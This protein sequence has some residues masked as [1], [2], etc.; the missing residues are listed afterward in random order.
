MAPSQ[1]SQLKSALQGAGLSRQSQGKKGKK[2]SKAGLTNKDREKKQQKLDEIRSNLNKFDVR[3]QKTKNPVVGHGVKKVA[4]GVVGTPSL[5]RQRGLEMRRETLLPEQS[6]RRAGHTGQF[7]DRRFGEDNPHITPEERALERFTRAREIERSAGGKPGR[8][9]IFNLNDDEDGIGGGLGFGDDDLGGG[10][11]GAVK[12]T[13]GGREINDLRGDDFSMQGLMDDDEIE[14]DF[15]INATSGQDGEDAYARRAAMGAYGED[16]NDDPDRVKTKAE[17]MAE[18]IAKSKMYKHERQKQKELDDDMRMELDEGLEELRGLLDPTSALPSSSV[19]SKTAPAEEPEDEVTKE[20][21]QALKSAEHEP[22]YDQYVRSLAFDRRAQPKDRTKT[23]EE[24]IKEE[25]EKLEAA[26]KARLRRMRGEESEEEDEASRDGPISRRKRRAKGKD[27][28]SDD[29]RLPKRQAGGDDLDDDFYDDGVDA[30]EAYGLGQG[31]RGAGSDANSEMDD[32]DEDEEVSEEE[33]S[34]SGED[35]DDENLDDLESND[36]DDIDDDDDEQSLVK[37]P[38]KWKMATNGTGKKEIP[39][40]FPCPTTH[41]DLL[42]IMNGLEDKDIEVVVKRIRTLYH[43]SRGE[44]NKERLQDLLGILIDHILYLTSDPSSMIIVSGLLPHLTALVQLNPLTAAEHFKAKLDIMQKNLAKGLAKGAT[45]P[46]S[47]TFPGSAELTF[48]RIVGLVW[49]TSDFSHPIGAPAELLMGQYLSQ[50][51]VRSLKDMASGLFLCSIFL[52]F[53]AYSKR[54]IP[55]VLNF[56][57]TTFMILGPSSMKV[58]PVPGSFPLGDMLESTGKERLSGLKLRSKLAAGAA[59]RKPNFP[60]LLKLETEEVQADEE[61]VEQ[62]KVDLLTVVIRLVM[63][64]A[65]MYSEVEAFVEVFQ[66]LLELMKALQTSKIPKELKIDALTR[67]IKFAMQA[68]QPLSMQTFKPIPIPSYT[69]KFDLHFSAASR[70]HQDPDAERNEANKVKALYKK[71]RKG[72][73]RE[74]RK[75]NKFL[76]VERAKEQKAKDEAYEKK[77]RQVHGS[78]ATT[79]RAEEKA[80]E[81][82]KARDKRRSGRK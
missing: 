40:T 38:R 8:K 12:L 63:T 2:N 50:A 16:E 49:S 28:D 71:E 34:G 22:D 61:Q 48:L 69:P 55:E 72:A 58:S 23:E 19:F 79:E 7:I 17:V 67:I 24:T 64:S 52:Q 42:D 60:D 39:F 6:L 75:D 20:D 65:E 3:E 77:M 46:Q 81:R 56:F 36:D 25:A 54:I 82:D 18:V 32:E 45:L 78:I 37:P 27:K 44:G 41:D 30:A 21:S 70:K 13:H 80:M 9:A 11:L 4:K 51:R 33:E 76:A 15:G 53:E 57:A 59:V 31:I 62:G 26:E 66:P 43:P 74:L 10:Q 68:R 1:L 14:D 5:S 73:I 29:E 35:D 47:R